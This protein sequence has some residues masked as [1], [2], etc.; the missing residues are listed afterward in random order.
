[1]ASWPKTPRSEHQPPVASEQ[2]TVLRPVE[3]RLSQNSLGRLLSQFSAVVYTR[4]AAVPTGTAS[5]PENG[6][7][8]RERTVRQL[9]TD[10]QRSFAAI[11]WKSLLGPHIYPSGRVAA[12][13]D[14]RDDPRR[15]IAVTVS[16]WNATMWEPLSST[17]T[18]AKPRPYTALGQ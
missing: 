15:A 17:Y 9:V 6:Q 8:A 14:P 11:A 12:C 13:P 4:E 5:P 1:M 7:S 18:P 3:A 2:R 10:K 16:E